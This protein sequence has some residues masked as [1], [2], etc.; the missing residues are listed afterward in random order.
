MF[1]QLV[2]GC[3]YPTAS[4]PGETILEKHNIES[5]TCWGYGSS[6]GDTEVGSDPAP[7][8]L[9]ILAPLSLPSRGRAGTLPGRKSFCTSD[10]DPSC[11]DFSKSR[12]CYSLPLLFWLLS[13]PL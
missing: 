7:G 4:L 10:L 13:L 6:A 11:C 12:P 5:W 8:L 9:A 2:L 3:V 1:R